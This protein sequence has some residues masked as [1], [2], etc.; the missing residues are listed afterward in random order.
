MPKADATLS[1]AFRAL[2]APGRLLIL[3]NA[4]DAGS[5]RVIEEL[6][7]PAIATTSAGLAWSRGYPDGGG[8]PPRALAAALG[9]IARAIRVPLTV[10]IEGGY[11]DSAAGAAET[12]AAVLDAGAVGINIEDGAA[13]ADLLCAKIEAARRVAARL[14]I[15]LFINARTDVYL[16]GLATGERAAAEI[17]VRAARYR[18]AGA[19]GLF[20]PRLPDEAAIRAAAAAAAP[21]P[22]NLM[23]APDLPPGAVLRALGVRRLSAGAAL[24]E[25]ALGLLRHRAT[26]F[27]ASGDAA[28]LFAGATPYPALNALFK[29]G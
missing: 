19:D 7:S 14:G 8:L 26:D 9:E 12:V 29:R 27:L 13:P 28:P 11:A 20:V 5:A 25:A 15:D 18:A 23:A 17:A 4:W 1:S 24:A 10:D 22:L 6:G 2:H 3:P 16:R 21:L